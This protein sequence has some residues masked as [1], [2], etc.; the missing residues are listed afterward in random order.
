MSA[1]W[2]QLAEREGLP[3]KPKFNPEEIK[4]RIWSLHC[5]GNPMSVIAEKIGEPVEYVHD[6][7]MLRLHK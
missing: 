3:Y 4:E 7:L 5:A 1:I 2:E 6:V